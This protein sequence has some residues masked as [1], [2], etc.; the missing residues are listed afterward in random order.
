MKR[1]GLIVALLLAA[2][3]A[4]MGVK[5]AFVPLPEAAAAGDG[6]F[7]TGRAMARLQRILGDQRPHP[8]DSAANDGVRDRLAAELAAL[9]LTPR[10]ADD[11]TC[12]GSAKSQT[13]SCARIR[14]VTATIGPAEGRHVLLVSHYDSTPAGPGAA[15]DGIGIASMLEVAA[16]AQRRAAETSG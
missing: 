11:F 13:V 6:G 1:T 14:N 15:D 16:L 3:L 5:G 10:I 8:V 4:V 9:G 2:L 7:D 12:N